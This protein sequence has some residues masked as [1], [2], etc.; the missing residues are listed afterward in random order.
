MKK[1][2]IVCLLFP[3]FG[4][5]QIDPIAL[6]QWKDLKY[7]MFIHFG[8]YSQLGGVWQGQQ[9]SRGLSE[10]IQ[11]H[12][13]I[14]SDVYEDVAKQ[15]N[16]EKW[17]PDSVALLAKSAG[18]G[19]VIITSK[20]HDGFAMFNSSHTD[21]DVVDATPYKKDIIAELSQAC[22][23]HQLKFGLYFSLIDWHFPQASPISSH[24]SD[25]IT[26]E[27][28]QFN[29][30][31]ITELLTN[32]GTIS[33]LWFDMGSMSLSQSKEMR[34]LVHRLQPNCM[35]GSRI[36]NDQGD[37]TVMGDNQEPDYIIGVPWQSPASFFDETWGYR[38]WQNRSDQDEKV[39]E[40]LTS[41]IRVASRGGNFLLNIGP[42]GNGSIVGYENDVLL[43]MGTWLRK[44]GGAIYNT[45]PDPFQVNFTWGAVTTSLRKLNLIVMKNPENR[46]IHLPG[47]KGVIKKTYVLSDG[48]KCKATK[49]ETGVMI[50]LPSS[51]NVS[52]EFKVLVLEFAGEFSVSPMNILKLDKHTV[53]LDNNNSFK[54]YSN[55][56]IDYATRFTST[57]KETWTFQPS[58]DASI[59]P[60]LF[61]TEEEKG[62]AIDLTVNDTTQTIKLT[63]GDKIP[64]VNKVASEEYGPLYLQGPFWSEIEGAHGIINEIDL[65]QPWPESQDKVWRAM[66][67]WT[68]GHLCTLPADRESAYYVL[69]EIESTED[70]KVMVKITSGDAL[71]VWINGKQRY[72]QINPLKRDSVAHF[73]VLDLQ[74]GKNQLL[75]KLFNN[76][77][78]RIHF[79]IDFS[80]PQV[81]Y[82]KELPIL[83]VK[84]NKLYSIDWKLHDPATPH[85]DMNVPNMQLILRHKGQ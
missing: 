2:I 13:G 75:I 15:F 35:I 52:S 79:A 49:T 83:N 47:L 72:L 56:G 82:R 11:A 9:V 66:P 24:N 21:F 63:D 76:F 8:I 10:Q 6:R 41:L 74:R 29:M 51:F 44:N 16:P 81:I 85:Q 14:Y 4:N 58:A 32:Y 5:A 60:E 19:S 71:T 43:R 65:N 3:C 61:Y 33:E 18:M 30:Q 22:Q 46:V 45:R 64:L 50:T 37:F 70:K 62:I 23:R 69:Q 78:K 57:I 20:H 68:N 27:H 42:K 1:I 28:H 53:S 12:A 17:N 73:I 25:F 80:V 39:R 67:D 40:K 34:T 54:Y 84:K 77:Q 31:Q 59:I 26:P 7:S 38:S 48:T 55:S 36:G